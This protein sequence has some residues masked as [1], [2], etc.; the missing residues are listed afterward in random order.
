M[1]VISV[2]REGGGS[3]NIRIDVGETAAGDEVAT[4]GGN[5]V[6]QVGTVIHPP[7]IRVFED[8]LR[9]AFKVRTWGE[10]DGER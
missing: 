9:K 3:T 2:N 5:V 4:V 10:H 8:A 6:K 1:D 7:H